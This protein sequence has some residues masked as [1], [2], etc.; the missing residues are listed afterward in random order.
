M[1]DYGDRLDTRLLPE[2]TAQKCSLKDITLTSIDA[3]F[4]ESLMKII[5]KD[6][7]RWLSFIVLTIPG[8]EPVIAELKA[9]LR[10]IWGK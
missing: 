1:R 10:V 3:L 8:K 7:E 9:K 5:E 4:S 6:W 2:L